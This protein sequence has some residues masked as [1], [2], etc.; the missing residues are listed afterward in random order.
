MPGH[1]WLT[2]LLWHIFAETRLEAASKVE[3]YTDYIAHCMLHVALNCCYSINLAS[4]PEEWSRN[5]TIEAMLGAEAHWHQPSTCLL[6][7]G[8]STRSCCCH[9]P[10]VATIQ[11]EDRPGRTISWPWNA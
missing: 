2:A 9:M 11:L 8:P 10:R 4:M 6:S 5:R 1:E 3:S 7:H